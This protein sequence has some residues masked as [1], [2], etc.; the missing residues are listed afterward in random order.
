MTAV[1][2][3]IDCY[4]LL[5]IERTADEI[6]I[7]KAYRRRALELHPDKNPDNPKAEELFLAVKA[8]S[9]TL[10]DKNLRAVLDAKLLA[11]D[12]ATARNNAMDS[13]RAR[14]R[15]E[16]EA[17]EKAAAD[18]AKRADIGAKELS[19]R[20]E[21]LRQ[22]GRARQ[23]EFQADMDRREQLRQ[24]TGT[25]ALEVDVLDIAEDVAEEEISQ[26]CVVKLN[27]SI[28]V[29]S[30]LGD[31]KDKNMNTIV[32]T[33]S[34]GRLRSIFKL[35]GHIS[36]IVARRAAT[37]SACIIFASADSA[38]AAI[39]VPPD[40]FLISR[41]ES[42]NSVKVKDV[43]QDETRSIDEES[44]SKSGKRRKHEVEEKDQI[45]IPTKT[46]TVNKLSFH[47]REAQVLS[48]LEKAAQKQIEQKTSQVT[49]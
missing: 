46:P 8:A 43:K 37:R 26:R 41:M 31:E 21:R 44:H 15:S 29:N 23:E 19:E 38:E 33:I 24:Q 30:R 32:T 36:S 16:L 25:D 49:Q 40:G 6:S 34:E 12:A 42:T 13:R 9:D 22:E 20:I 11:R 48:R 28:D 18:L 5:G 27:W 39:A 4:V 7:R 17:R 1:P 14:L 3:L 10:L 45:Q 35:Y 47:D 2:S